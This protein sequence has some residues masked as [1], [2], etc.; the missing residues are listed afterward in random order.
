MIYPRVTTKSNIFT[1]HVIAQSL[2]QG[3]TDL[4]NGTWT[5]NVDQV[6]GEVRGAYTIEKYYDPNVDDLSYYPSS[7]SG[8][9][10]S[11]ASSDGSLTSTVA[12]RGARWRLLNVKRF[13]Q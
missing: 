12:L 7:R 1:V 11:L 13:G 3:P 4:A 2:K 6:T 5:E 10:A 8:P 9:V